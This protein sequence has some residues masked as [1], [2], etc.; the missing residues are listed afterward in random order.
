MNKKIYKTNEKRV[1]TSNKC[2]KKLPLQKRNEINQ[3][4]D[5]LLKGIFFN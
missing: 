4:V 2:L 5:K 3:L 1:N